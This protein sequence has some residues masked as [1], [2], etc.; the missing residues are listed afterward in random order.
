MPKVIAGERVVVRDGSELDGRE[1]ETQRV[2]DDWAQVILDGDEVPI[3]FPLDSIK[4]IVTSEVD[5]ERDTPEALK[6][7]AEAT[8]AIA[9]ANHAMTDAE[10]RLI[11]EA[12]E[13]AKLFPDSDDDAVLN[14]IAKALIL[15]ASKLGL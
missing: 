10:A 13:Y 7:L 12:A 4:R 2:R 1:G 5:R 3:R 14:M 9:R 15:A 8:D 11:A 6:D